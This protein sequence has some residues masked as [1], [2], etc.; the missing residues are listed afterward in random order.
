M[1]PDF[2]S[3]DPETSTMGTPEADDDLEFS[4]LDGNVSIQALQQTDVS[5]VHF[6]G[7]R[8]QNP[9]TSRHTV[10]V[11]AFLHNVQDW[12]EEIKLWDNYSQYRDE[13]LET[14]SEFRI[15]WNGHFSRNNVAEYRIEHLIDNVQPIHSAT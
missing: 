14:L 12:Q 13:L 2:D 1:V 11:N 5:A 6:N 15:T 10:Y 4:A 7:A 3:D 8:H 9:Q